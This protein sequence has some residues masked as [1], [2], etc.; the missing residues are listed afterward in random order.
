MRKNDK[1]FFIQSLPR[2]LLYIFLVFRAICEY[3]ASKNLPPL[4]RTIHR[5]ISSHL[6]TNQSAAQQM[7]KV[8]DANKYSPVKSGE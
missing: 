6:R 1:K 4:L 8:I 5:A 7:R 2:R 3:H